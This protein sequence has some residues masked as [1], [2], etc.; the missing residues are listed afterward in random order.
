ACRNAAM[1]PIREYMR[2]HTTPGGELKDIDP[3]GMNI[4][5]LRLTDFF[6]PDN[7]N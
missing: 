4:R 3:K 2:N 6:V 7:P 5:P 1:I